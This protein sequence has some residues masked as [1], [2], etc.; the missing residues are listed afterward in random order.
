MGE[1]E[2]D[3]S[4][5]EGITRRSYEIAAKVSL[6]LAM[7][8]GGVRT[9]EHVLYGFAFAKADTELK[10]EYAYSSMNE[11]AI[12]SDIRGSAKLVKLLSKLSYDTPVTRGQ[13]NRI[14]RCSTT[15]EVSSYLADLEKFG[16][17]KISE[18]VSAN[19]R[20]CEFIVRI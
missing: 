20:P 18:G 11:D 2:K 9:A 16:K 12:D 19:N 5:L 4:G 15:A 7:A 10:I 6:I 1:R 14:M 3:K 8:D 17:I 13:V